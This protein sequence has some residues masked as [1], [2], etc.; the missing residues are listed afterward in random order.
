MSRNR[1]RVIEFEGARERAKARALIDRWQLQGFNMILCY[2]S[3]FCSP[4]NSAVIQS[5][6]PRGYCA[7]PL[8][9]D[10]A[11]DTVMTALESGQHFRLH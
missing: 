8:D 9:S 11:L 3:G 7:H 2:P 5:D 10:E 1:A 4:A 6:L